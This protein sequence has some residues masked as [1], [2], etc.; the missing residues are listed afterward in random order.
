[1]PWGTKMSSELKHYI[2]LVVEQKI[3][4]VEVA[5][6]KA[7]W[8]SVAHINDLEARIE[9]AIRV[10]DGQP[11]RSESRG[12]YRDFVNRLKR[13]L[14]SARRIAARRSSSQY[15]HDP[16]FSDKNVEESSKNG[17]TDRILREYMRIVLSENEGGG[18]AGTSGDMAR[19]GLSVADISAASRGGGGGGKGSPGQLWSTFISPFTDV[20]KTV[21]GK[22]EEVIRKSWTPVNVALHTILTSIIPGLGHSY[23]STFENEKRDIEKIRGKYKDV[24]ARTNK[25]LSSNDAAFFAFLASPAEAMAGL[26]LTKS[27]GSVL[28]ALSYLSGGASDKIIRGELTNKLPNMEASIDAFLRKINQGVNEN[29][30]ING[31]KHINEKKE[32]SDD[33]IEKELKDLLGNEEF[34]KKI[35]STGKARSQIEEMKKSVDD[36]YLPILEKIKE[37]AEKA[38]SS[39]ATLES[40]KEIVGDDF[41]KVIESL[42]QVKSESQEENEDSKKMIDLAK[43]EILTNTQK[44]L[45]NLYLKALKKRVKRIKDAGIPA[46]SKYLVDYEKT[47]SYIKSL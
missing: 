12:F 27:P 36:I 45:K 22:G 14:T 2:S 18:D 8:G 23:K 11:P 10:R 9:H 28:E 6:G 43:K 35:L 40:I 46:T 31:K 26:A 34:I 16:S 38:L 17:S 39:A 21:Q 32:S 42:K 3:R 44:A 37:E 29:L 33:K 13:E 47:I 5:A 19:A 41:S 15:S 25:A 4:E 7:E 1:M 30:L 20:F 24:Y